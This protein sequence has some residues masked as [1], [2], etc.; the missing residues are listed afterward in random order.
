M[1]FVFVYLTLKA[2]HKNCSRR[3]FNSLLLSFEKIKE[4]SLETLSLIF[5]E[6]Q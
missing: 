1:N 4:D 5:S 2:P 6:K 3:H